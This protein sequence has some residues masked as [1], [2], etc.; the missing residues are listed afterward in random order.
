VGLG[1]QLLTEL[2]AIHLGHSDVS[3]DDI[4]ALLAKIAPRFG[5]T[6]GAP[7]HFEV[8]LAIQELGD[9]VANDLVIVDYEQLY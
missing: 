6:V 7:N 4:R 3:E 9:G 1:S 2:E 8:L 5:A